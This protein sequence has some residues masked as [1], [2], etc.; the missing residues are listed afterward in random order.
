MLLE[1]FFRRT[2]W[3]IKSPQV[4]HPKASRHLGSTSL[5]P[6]VEVRVVQGACGERA[7][8]VVMILLA[9]GQYSFVSVSYSFDRNS[10]S[11]TLLG[12]P[13]PAIVASR[14]TRVP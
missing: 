2:A 5:Q 13:A 3:K 4:C 6:A 9:F 10:A 14:L 1:R 12:A 7:E 8:G 11:H